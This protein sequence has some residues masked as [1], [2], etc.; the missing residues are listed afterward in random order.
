M[1]DVITL[2]RMV[3]RQTRHF[4]PMLALSCATVVDGGTTLSQH[5]GQG[6]VSIGRTSPDSES[7]AM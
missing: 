4:E 7:M 3:C 1:Q 5:W 6:V 2:R